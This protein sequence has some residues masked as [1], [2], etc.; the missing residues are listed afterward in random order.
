MITR[1][2]SRK[3]RAFPNAIYLSFVDWLE[4]LPRFS[5]TITLL[6]WA[7]YKPSFVC[8]AVRKRQMGCNIQHASSY[9]GDSRWGF[10]GFNR[11]P[12]GLWILLEPWIRFSVLSF[13][14]TILFHW[15][16]CDQAHIGRVLQRRLH[17][18]SARGNTLSRDRTKLCTWSK[19]PRILRLRL[20]GCSCNKKPV[21][22]MAH[23]V[24]YRA[25]LKSYLWL[26]QSGWVYSHRVE[27]SRRTLVQYWL[28]DG[29][30]ICT[31]EGFVLDISRSWKE[32][33]LLVVQYYS[34]CHINSRSNLVYWFSAYGKPHLFVSLYC[35]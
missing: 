17:K 7:S 23:S 31:K 27:S 2:G 26:L 11:S 32:L 25:Y 24:V 5:Q 15:K 13:C 19:I 4:R 9:T 12:S 1:L 14:K 29:A 18:S 35:S 10:E 28:L 6:S 30:T 34:P 16:F 3:G 33:R 20:T 22:V 21:I 8:S